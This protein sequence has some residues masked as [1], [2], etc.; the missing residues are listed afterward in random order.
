MMVSFVLKTYNSINLSEKLISTLRVANMPSPIDRR[1]VFIANTALCLNFKLTEKTVFEDAIFFGRQR[2]W[3]HD[4][5][6][7]QLFALLNSTMKMC[8]VLRR[9]TPNEKPTVDCHG[10]GTQLGSWVLHYPGKCKWIPKEI[11]VL[12]GWMY[13]P[14]NWFWWHSGLYIKRR[15]KFN[16]L[17]VSMSLWGGG[18]FSIDFNIPMLNLST[19]LGIPLHNLLFSYSG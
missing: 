16:I 9:G 13:H 4:A 5:R 18:N 11:I 12:I 6:C 2:W 17:N 15:R 3:W 1:A 8:L 14:C 7:S 19:L 10:M